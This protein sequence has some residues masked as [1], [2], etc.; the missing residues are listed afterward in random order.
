MTILKN[1]TYYDFKSFREDAYIVF[2][3]RILV[4]GDMK[5]YDEMAYEA[6]DI[7]DVKYH[8]VMPSLVVG[9][10]HV[11]SALSRGLSV[12]FNPKDFRELLE[13]LWWKLDD[14]LGEEEIYYSGIVSGIDH[15]K[16]GVTT[17]IDHHASGLMIEGSLEVLKKAIIDDISLRGIFCFETSDRFDVEA[18]IREN[19]SFIK[20]HQ[21]SDRA[22]GLFG[23]HA[24]LT[25]SEKSL[26]QIKESIGETPLHI[27]VAESLGEAE[28]CERLYGERVIER[29]DRYG[30]LNK[31]SLLSHCIHINEDERKI[32][33]KRGCTVAVNVSSNM[34]NGVGL[35]DLL[36]MKREGIKLIIG[37]DGISPSIMNES[38]TLLFCMHH[39]Y[40]SPT[41]F[42]LSHLLEIIQN[43][44]EYANIILNTKLGKIEVG[45][46][47]D[48]MVL[49]YNPPTPFDQES[50]LGHL[51]FGLSSSLKPKHVFCAGK[52]IVRDYEVNE[53]LREK[54]RQAKD[55][56]KYLWE[57]IKYQEAK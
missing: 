18:C 47:S 46:E 5:D 53:I 26:K 28:E 6:Q 40:S 20:R 57:K 2:E 23:A 21:H 50:A 43:T 51:I 9:H 36:K 34:N 41:D 14:R 10:T 44:Y 8:L 3:G 42:N 17:L 48:L 38:A 33:K 32:I 1:V 25:L 16:N 7:L 15:V 37:N 4:V 39:Y 56:G 49:P 27:H 31:N 22:K 24:M 54:Y 11:Y 12:A 29:L 55:H 30:L 19:V 45:Y 35:P 13:Q 52:W